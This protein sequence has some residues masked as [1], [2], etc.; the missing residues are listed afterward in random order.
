VGEGTKSAPERRLA[1]VPV[2]RNSATLRQKRGSPSATRRRGLAIAKPSL[3][4]VRFGLA[5]RT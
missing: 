4:R 1:F 3:K 2:P 5:P